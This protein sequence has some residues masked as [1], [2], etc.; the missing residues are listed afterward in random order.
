MVNN[1]EMLRIHNFEVKV[2]TAPR[3]IWPDLTPCP[4]NHCG[5]N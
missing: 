1:V 4:Q 5:S 2:S 3:L